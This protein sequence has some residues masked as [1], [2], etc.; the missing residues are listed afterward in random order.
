MGKALSDL[1]ERAGSWPAWAQEKLVQAALEIESRLSEPYVLSPEEIAA[2]DE[3]EQSGVA[4]PE[5]V[6]AAFARFRGP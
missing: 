4:T 2:I 3:A 6:E 1:I 5:E